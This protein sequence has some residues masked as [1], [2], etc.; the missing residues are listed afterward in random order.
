[1]KKMRIY[2]ELEGKLGTQPQLQ[3]HTSTSLPDKNSSL[4]KTLAP[5]KADKRRGQSASKKEVQG[6][7]DCAAYANQPNFAHKPNLVH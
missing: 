5:K 1:M 3:P 2:L 6:D 7:S 4:W